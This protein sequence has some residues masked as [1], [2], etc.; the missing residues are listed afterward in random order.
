MFQDEQDVLSILKHL[1]HPVQK[2][3]KRGR[4]A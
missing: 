3:L 4:S 2:Y 1:V